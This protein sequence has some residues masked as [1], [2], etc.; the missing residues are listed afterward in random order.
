MHS[1]PNRGGKRLTEYGSMRDRIVGSRPYNR[2]RE[3]RHRES[4]RQAVAPSAAREG[5]DGRRVTRAMAGAAARARER[6]VRSPLRA[7][8]QTSV[9]RP[10]ASIP[11]ESAHRASDRVAP[12]YRPSDH[13]DRFSYRMGEPRHVRA[14]IPRRRRRKPGRDSIAGEVRVALT[15][16]RAGLRSQR[17]APPESHE[18]SFG[19][20]RAR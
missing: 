7:I 12:R 4:G 3:S 18:R 17:G 1:R 8:L 10:A 2:P 5:P 15:R 9:R 13:R 6:R 19:E 14:H 16:E 11:T 20:A